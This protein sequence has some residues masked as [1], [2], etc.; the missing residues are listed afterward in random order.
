M[1]YRQIICT[2][3][4]VDALFSVWF[5]GNYMHTLQSKKC[6]KV[7]RCWRFRVCA[8]SW[9]NLDYIDFYLTC[10]YTDPVTDS[11]ICPHVQVGCGFRFSSCLERQVF[12]NQEDF[13]NFCRTVRN[14]ILNQF[15]FIRIIHADIVHVSVISETLPEKFAW[16]GP[17]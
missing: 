11:T 8:V 16:P 1:R 9:L 4:W 14:C 7:G 3:L 13:N 5:H 10:T 12:I 2:V 15:N 17:L 6:F